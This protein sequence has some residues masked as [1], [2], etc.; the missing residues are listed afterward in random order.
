MLEGGLDRRRRD[1]LRRRSRRGDQRLLEAN[2]DGGPSRARTLA[3]EDDGD[4]ADVPASTGRAPHA[5]DTE[6]T[7]PDTG[8]LPAETPAPGSDDAVRLEGVWLESAKGQVLDAPR[9]HVPF[10]ICW[11]VRFARPAAAPGFR[12][13]LI[14]A[15][16]QVLGECDTEPTQVRTGVYEPGVVE[17]VRSPLRRGVGAGEYRVVCTCTV[18]RE[19]GEAVTEH[20]A[21]CRLKVIGSGPLRAVA[22][23]PK[24]VLYLLLADTLTTD[25]AYELSVAGV[26]NINGLPGGGGTAE[27]LRQSSQRE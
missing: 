23:L 27:V 5:P 10:D 16:G 8:L 11:A 21:S 14:D 12:L 15:A 1:P 4:P 25:Q 17:M 24:Q 2:L 9:A 6:A 20:V 13:E 22:D 26:T 18:P 7:I 19:G 3:V